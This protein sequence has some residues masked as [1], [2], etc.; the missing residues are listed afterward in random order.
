MPI[1]SVNLSF[2]KPRNLSTCKMCASWFGYWSTQL[3]KHQM[4]SLLC[5][6]LT[7][8]AI[9]SYCA[10]LDVAWKFNTAVWSDNRLKELGM[11]FVS[12]SLH[13]MHNTP[14]KLHYQIIS[15]PA[16]TIFLVTK[17]IWSQGR[18]NVSVYAHVCSVCTVFCT[19]FCT[20]TVDFHACCWTSQVWEYCNSTFLFTPQNL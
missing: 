11:F 10:E 1:S 13:L 16:W 5:F 7:C 4:W 19:S 6:S 14:S 9:V 15:T 17:N 8:D 3:G 18:H 2:L 12:S 20:S